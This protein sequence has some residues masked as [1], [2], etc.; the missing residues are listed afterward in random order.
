[1]QIGLYRYLHSPARQHVQQSQDNVK[2]KT[3]LI[4][5]VQWHTQRPAAENQTAD[6]GSFI[7]I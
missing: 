7:C 2:Q 1:M 3:T 6:F 5:N 4:G